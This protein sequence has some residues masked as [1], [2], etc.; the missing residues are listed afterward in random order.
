M[1]IA[2]TIVDSSLGRLLVAATAK[3]VSAVAIADDDRR[4]ERELREEY[5]RAQVRRDDSALAPRIAP[6]LAHLEGRGSNLDLPLDVRATA[7]QVRVFEELR[8]IPG[9]ETRTYGQVA[10]AM[11]RPDAARAVARACATNPVSI[12]VPCHRV[13]GKGGGLTGYRWG[14]DRKRKLLEI[15]RR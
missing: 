7:F 5:P 12:V 8:R 10:R 14:L 4:L 11:G 9:G 3:G 2:Y 13:V 6:I 1:D 15:E